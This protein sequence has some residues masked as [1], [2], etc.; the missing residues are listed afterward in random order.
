MLMSEY[1]A[2][3]FVTLETVKDGPIRGIIKDVGMG[4]YDK[5]VLELEDGTKFSLNKT[6]VAILIKAFGEDSREWPG[7]E[8]EL[9]R[10]HIKYNG[11]LQD[12]VLARPVLPSHDE[13]PFE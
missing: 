1:S 8:I 2:K 12:A 11:S 6:N 10:G 9:R 3:S 7:C 4:S 5:P 13:T